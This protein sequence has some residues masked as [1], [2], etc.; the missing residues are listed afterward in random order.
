MKST[1]KLVFMA[2]VAG[3]L[4]AGYKALE[5]WGD[6][7]ARSDSTEIE[8]VGTLAMISEEQMGYR[9]FKG[10]YTVGTARLCL[11][12]QGQNYLLIFDKNSNLTALDGQPSSNSST[13]SIEGKSINYNPS[14]SYRVLGQK[15]SYYALIPA[16]QIR[17][18]DGRV[19]DNY[20]EDRN[21]VYHRIVVAKIMPM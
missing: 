17:M 21:S 16:G 3:F 5:K 13:L 20:K 7:W 15:S 14:A 9:Q 12:S 8:F 11:R 19:V 2:F 4:I 1:L 6:D 10:N 18:S